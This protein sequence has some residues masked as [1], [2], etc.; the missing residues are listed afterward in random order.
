MIVLFEQ[1][2]R[3][4][5]SLCDLCSFT[6]LVWVSLHNYRKS[7]QNHEILPRVWSSTLMTNL[8]LLYHSWRNAVKSD[9]KAQ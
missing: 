3:T 2:R 6:Q 7:A 8:P 5:P 9:S 1:T 4:P